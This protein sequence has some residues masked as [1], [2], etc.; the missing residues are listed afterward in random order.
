MFIRL[1]IYSMLISRYLRGLVQKINDSYDTSRENARNWVLIPGK[2][3]YPVSS[4]LRLDPS[5]GSGWWRGAACQ[6]HIPAWARTVQS[7]RNLET[8]NA[9]QQLWQY[10]CWRWLWHS[11]SSFPPLG[12][13][14][15]KFKL[16]YL[17]WGS[18]FNGTMP[19]SRL[20]TPTQF[21]K[22][23]VYFFKFS[24]ILNK[25]FLSQPFT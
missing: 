12:L 10:S 19:E 3:L 8:W 11:C 15:T 18:L 25:C 9:W 2:G 22:E 13:C 23:I 1:G 17:L 5:S 4:S 24:L 14:W 7:D 6:P 16:L 20:P 21:L